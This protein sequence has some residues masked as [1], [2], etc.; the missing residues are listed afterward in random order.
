MGNTHPS[1][2]KEAGMI[3]QQAGTFS[4]SRRAALRVL[5]MLSTGLG[6]SASFAGERSLQDIGSELGSLPEIVLFKARRVITMAE[7]KTD[8]EAVAVVG[9]RILAVG[10]LADLERLAGSQ[11]YR[12]DTQFADKVL[13]AGLIDQHVHPVLAALTMTLDIT[14]IEDW[15]LPTGTSKAALDPK[16]YME[17]IKAA[18]AAMTDPGE[19]FLT[20]GYHHY[21]HGN[22][23]RPELD[24][25]SS[26][27]PIIIWHRSAHEFILNT[28][29]LEKYGITREVIDSLPATAKAQSSY[30]DGHFYEQGMFAVLPKLASVLA[31]RERLMAGLNLTRDYLH[32]SGVTLACEPGGIVSKPLQDAQNLVLGSAD[33]PFRMYYM[34]DGKTMAQLHIDKDIIGETKA[35]LSW[36]SGKTAYLPDQVKLFADG[37][38]YSQ[39]MQVTEPYTDGHKG[40]WIMEPELFDRAFDAYWAAGYHIHIHQNGDGGLDLVLNALE[41]NMRRLPRSN[42]RTTVV[43][44]GFARQDQISRIRALGAIV[45]ANPYYV[46]AL[47]DRYAEIGL[48]KERADRLVP[49]GEVAKE[50]ISISFHSD[51]PMAPGQ[52]LFLVWAAVNRTTSSG[53]VAG[54]EQRLTLEQALRA[55]TIDA[56]YSIEMENDV[57]S[58]EPGKLANFTILEEDPF[59]VNADRIKD[60]RVWGTVTEGTVHP[61]L[62][63]A[64]RKAMIEAPGSDAVMPFGFNSVETAG[65]ARRGMNQGCSCCQSVE[66]ATCDAGPRVTSS[67]GCCA[68]NAL[69]WAVAALWASRIAS[70]T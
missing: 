35:V 6:T 63:A 45:S 18:E 26:K 17:R 48:G 1:V 16:T 15:V 65:I 43:H 57:G 46:T 2:K 62:P 59:D 68:T 33:S 27:R 20:W 13:I 34:P 41:R 67:A 5:A 12:V 47:S 9:S 38:I 36:G 22:V 61:V 44:F 54:P 50:G 52:P 29:A 70:P 3:G 21:W 19:P 55:V 32:Q 53:R 56:A 8:A 30:E 23:R 40:E 42:H 14:A 31:T 49:V 69:G 66:T 39:L 25:I 4:L 28:P 37:A 64:N 10:K 60:I 11:P 24:A 51:M 58:I 7:G